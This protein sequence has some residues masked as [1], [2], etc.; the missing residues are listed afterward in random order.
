[1]SIVKSFS[2]NIQLITKCYLYKLMNFQHNIEK[3]HQTAKKK[4]VMALFFRGKL[5]IKRMKNSV[6]HNLK[7]SQQ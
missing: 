5:R 3:N 7:N 2:K 6:V 4:T 1:M